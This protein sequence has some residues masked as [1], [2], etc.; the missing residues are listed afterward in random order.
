M[1]RLFGSLSASPTIGPLTSAR[2]GPSIRP[3]P[4]SHSQALSRAGLPNRSR[5]PPGSSTLLVEQLG[6]PRARRQAGQLARASRSRGGSRRT[7][8][9]PAAGGR[10][11]ASS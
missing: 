2:I 5:N 7:A 9:R 10:G 6:R 3:V 8:P 11:R 1:M 4:R